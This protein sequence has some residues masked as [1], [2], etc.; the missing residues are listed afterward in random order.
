MA[1]SW[2]RVKSLRLVRQEYAGSASRAGW[3][4]AR[5]TAR[6]DLVIGCNGF[7]EHGMPSHAP[8]IQQSSGSY[9]WTALSA[10]FL[11]RVSANR[12][13]FSCWSAGLVDGLLASWL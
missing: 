1:N 2:G 10:I 6:G 9:N 13:G 11:N 5:A 8:G 7:M 3:N 12:F 4:A